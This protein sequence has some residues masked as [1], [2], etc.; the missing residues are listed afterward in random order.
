MRRSE[1]IPAVTSSNLLLILG[2][3]DRFLEVEK[4]IN[5]FVHLLI[6]EI[7]R[8]ESRQRQTQRHLLNTF[9]L[10]RIFPELGK[11]RMLF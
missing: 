8:V 3:P 9:H 7:R 5:L 10:K 11:F 4:V 2:D 1:Q 6:I